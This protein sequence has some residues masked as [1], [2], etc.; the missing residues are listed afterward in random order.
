L[1]LLDVLRGLAIL[2]TLAT[3]VWIF[4]TPGSEGT[5]LSSSDAVSSNQ[6]NLV[7]ATFR[8]LTNGK[9]LSLL[10]VLFGVGLAIQFASAQRR[11]SVWPGRYRWRA[12]FLFAEGTI[13]FIFVFAYDVL[14]G[15]AVTALLVAWLLKRSRR[16]QSVVMWTAG[17][18]HVVMMTG[19]SLLSLV[20]PSES[21]KPSKV[22]PDQIDLYANGSYLEQV[23]SRLEN[24]AM[25]RFEPVLTFA[26]LVFLFFVGVR[27]FQAGAFAA[28]DTGR[29]LRSRLMWWGL[30]VGIPLSIGCAVVGSDVFVFDRYVV[31]PVVAIGYLGAVGVLLDRIRPGRITMAFSNLGRTAL[32]GYVFQNVVCSLVC[33]GFGLGLA[34]KWDGTGSWW[35]LAL[36]AIL[37]VSMLVGSTLWLRRFSA[38]PLEALQKRVLRR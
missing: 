10:T 5:L 27:L 24:M 22:D 17:I 3:N 34:D 7:E 38:G 35:V 36:W 9:S 15:Y 19:L 37:S 29:R 8:L 23:Q 11:G 26:L 14:M 30:G 2:G 28:G 21:D 16:A 4:A 25:F 33:Y 31:A 18:L 20:D 12:L 32:S 6:G 1:P 13:H